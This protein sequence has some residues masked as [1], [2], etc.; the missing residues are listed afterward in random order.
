MIRGGLGPTRGANVRLSPRPWGERIYVVL[1]NKPLQAPSLNSVLERDFKIISLPPTAH[2]QTSAPNQ[3]MLPLGHSRA[4]VIKILPQSKMWQD[5]KKSFDDWYDHRIYLF[6]LLWYGK[7]L[8]RSSGWCVPASSG[9][10]FRHY[11]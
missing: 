1:N 10:A 6:Q 9:P 4:T 2:L 8:Q 7:F 5:A 11:F 3:L